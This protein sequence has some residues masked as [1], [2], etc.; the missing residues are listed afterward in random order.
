MHKVEKI[1]HVAV[2]PEGYGLAIEACLRGIWVEE[3]AG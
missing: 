2:K 3:A 1:K